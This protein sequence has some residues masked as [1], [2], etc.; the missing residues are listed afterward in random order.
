MDVFNL[1]QDDGK[2]DGKVLK[3]PKPPCKPLMP[4]MRYS[5]KVS[6]LVIV[7]FCVI[8]SKVK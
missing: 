1:L 6:R 5:R 4:Y 2:D 7:P 8:V 3:Q